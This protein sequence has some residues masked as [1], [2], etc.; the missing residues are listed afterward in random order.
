MTKKDLDKTDYKLLHYLQQ[1]GRATNVQL[2]EQLNLSEA[3]CWRR[4]RNLESSGI[5]EGY[6][7][8]LNRKKLGFEIQAF[9]LLQFSVHTGDS[10]EM[11]EQSVQ[12]IPEVLS[13]HNVAGEADYILVIIAKDLASYE[14][15]LRNTIRNL[16][17]VS[18]M[19]TIMSLKE[20]KSSKTLPLPL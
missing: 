4:Q 19:K 17:G 1:Y 20:V 15:L 13:C 8:N 5:I 2:A 16:P 11:F 10:P 18:S 9:V 3:P 6:Q 7:A 12:E 14:K